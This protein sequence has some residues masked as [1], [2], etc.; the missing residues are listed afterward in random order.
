MWQPMVSGEEKMTRNERHIKKVMESCTTREQLKNATGWFIKLR[1][2]GG[3]DNRT[4][5]YLTGLLR[6]IFVGLKL[7]EE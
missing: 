6:G 5:V 3:I 7:E 2:K 1:E 4:M